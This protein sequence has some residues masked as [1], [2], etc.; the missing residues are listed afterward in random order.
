LVR[1]HALGATWL[2]IVVVIK[3]CGPANAVIKFFEGHVRYPCSVK[4]CELNEPFE[5]ESAR[6]G[7]YPKAI[8]K[9]FSGLAGTRAIFGKSI[10]TLELTGALTRGMVFGVGEEA[11]RSITASD[12]V[13]AFEVVKLVD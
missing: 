4:G 5:Q 2:A 7:V 8:G 3:L 12:I 9:F 11:V 10:P 1:H 6:C 13:C